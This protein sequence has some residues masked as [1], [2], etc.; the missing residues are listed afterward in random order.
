MKSIRE[1]DEEM[2]LRCHLS[3]LYYSCKAFFILMDQDVSLYDFSAFRL[4]QIYNDACRGIFTYLKA[5]DL[6][7]NDAF[8]LSDLEGRR[9]SFAAP[10]YR[11]SVP[12]EAV[13]DFS[14]CSDYAVKALRQMNRQPGL[15][16]P[17]VGRIALRQFHQALRMPA[18]T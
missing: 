4:M 2:A 14:L 12:A 7:A 8:S 5:H 10:R 9:F 6:L 18:G 17:L 1:K 13:A 3:A 15:G 11:L 16:V